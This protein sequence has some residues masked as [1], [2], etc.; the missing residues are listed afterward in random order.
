MS[1]GAL[2]VL[3]PRFTRGSTVEQ[4]APG[5]WRLSLP[6]GQKGYRLAQLDDYAG[7]PRRAFHTRRPAVLSLRARLSAAGLPGTW[8]FGFWNDPFSAGFGAGGG[9]LNLGANG[10][11]VR[12]QRRLRTG[13]RRAAVLR[14]GAILDGGYGL[15]G[16]GIGLDC[17]AKR[18]AAGHRKNPRR[19]CFSGALGHSPFKPEILLLEQRAGGV[20]NHPPGLPGAALQSANHPIC[21]SPAT[22][23]SSER[24]R[25]RL[26]RMP[27]SSAT[28]TRSARCS[29]E[30]AAHRKR[31]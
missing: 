26:R 10:G 4:L 12:I 18:E 31:R 15:P 3:N 5:H 20:G 13:R 30:A 21:S 1:S 6:A 28:V 7:L 2:P 11:R 22:M 25:S 17:R 27:V 19:F 14:R 29:C 16:Q 24:D 8:G 9:G 23:A